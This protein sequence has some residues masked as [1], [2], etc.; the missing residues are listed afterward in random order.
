MD[1]LSSTET[2]L[3]FGLL[4]TGICSGI[5]LFSV[6]SSAR[7][8]SSKLGTEPRSKRQKNREQQ[9]SETSTAADSA[10]SAFSN[11]NSNTS[12]GNNSNTSIGVTLVN[13]PLARV[14]QNNLASRPASAG[15][16]IGS[17]GPIFNSDDIPIPAHD[18]PIQ[19][20]DIPI[21][22][23]SDNSA[24]LPGVEVWP[25]NESENLL[26]LIMSIAEE[27]TLSGIFF[28]DLAVYNWF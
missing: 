11:N 4:V 26:N 23:I 13:N 21:T 18:I 12:L 27:Q 24:P 20:H 16:N 2:R 17:R 10:S 25:I 8:T 5:F 3:K 6:L 9:I 28:L 22:M 14:F 1:W 19:V 15:L 7:N